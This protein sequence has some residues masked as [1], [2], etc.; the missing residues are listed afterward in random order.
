MKDFPVWI[1]RVGIQYKKNSIEIC[2]SEQVTIYF[3]NK[4]IIKITI[5]LK[6]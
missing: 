6:K 2:I 3:I 1:K 5:C 4:P